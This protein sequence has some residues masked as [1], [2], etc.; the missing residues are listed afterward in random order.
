MKKVNKFIENNLLGLLITIFLVGILSLVLLIITSNK[1]EDDIARLEI[2]N[3][4]LKHE[5]ITKR[6]DNEM[7]GYAIENLQAQVDGKKAVECDL[8]IQE[9]EKGY[10]IDGYYYEL[11][12][13]VGEE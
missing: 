11:K 1:Y 5:L 6:K 12:E 8:G 13:Q 10:I 2:E 3:K 4:K 9:Y 7:M